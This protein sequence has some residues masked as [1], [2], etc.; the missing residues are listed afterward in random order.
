MNGLAYLAF[1]SGCALVALIICLNSQK[2]GNYLNLMDI[3]TGRKQHRAA[4]P[5]I[6]GVTL[7]GAFVPISIIHI[8]S[9]AS[10]RWL[11]TLLLWVGCIAL[12]ALVG[13]ADDRHSLS[14]KARLAISFAVFGFAALF[15]PTLNVRVLDFDV[16]KF[17]IGLGTRWLA[18]L[19]TVICC[20]GLIN[21]I[22]MADGKNGLVLGLSLGW[23][24]ILALRAPPVLQPVIMILAVSL[25]VLFVFNMRGLLFL[26][27][28]GA[29]A[30]AT[31]IGLLAI[32]IYNTPG[33]TSL[34]SISAE[35]IVV[36][37]AVPIFDSFRLTYVR[38]REGRSPM[39]GDRDHFHHH[40]QTIFGW[41]NGLFIYWFVGLIPA[42]AFFALA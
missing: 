7:L 12:M 39:D 22:N 38:M 24:G 36:L 37:F 18:A 20:V 15:D 6:G 30:I 9:T 10:E 34:R 4:T 40:L 11:V 41:P 2:V 16:P 28:G 27:D 42:L 3:P 25:F 14:P 29:Y 23:L 19:F 21:A 1:A 13:I 31:A 17:S 5:L 26:G 8:V 35:E 33:R 32:M